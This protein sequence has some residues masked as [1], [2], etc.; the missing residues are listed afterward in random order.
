MILPGTRVLDRNGY[1]GTVKMVYDDFSA[2]AAQ[3]VTMT[4]DEWLAEQLVPFT[5]EHME[6]VWYCVVFGEEAGGG[7][8]WSPESLLEVRK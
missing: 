7:A 1:P 3:C 6:E 8:V 5:P 4:G 2:C